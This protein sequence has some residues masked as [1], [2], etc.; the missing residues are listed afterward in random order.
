MKKLSF[1]LIILTLIFFLSVGI[2]GLSFAIYGSSDPLF[3]RDF[4]VD[5][6]RMS[7][8]V[9]KLTFIPAFVSI[10]VLEFIVKK[11][12]IIFYGLCGALTGI[13]ILFYFSLHIGGGDGLA[14]LFFSFFGAIGGLSFGFL[15]YLA[16]GLREK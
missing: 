4:F 5:W 15:R 11:P 7:E 1:N 2:V 10:I 13:L 3:S 14:A 6:R 9:L 16:L 8:T 12:F